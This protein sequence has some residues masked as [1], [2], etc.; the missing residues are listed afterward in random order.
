MRPGSGA[1]V[2]V[3]TGRAEPLLVRAAVLPAEPTSAGAARRLLLD[4]LRETGRERWADSGTL[5]ITEVVTNAVLH[6]ATAVEVT[7]AVLPDEVD[8]SVFDRSPVLPLPRTY[9][10]QATTGRGLRLVAAVTAEC[11][12]EPRDDPRGKDVWFRIR[13][14]EPVDEASVDDLLAAWDLEVGA[15][16]AP[17]DLDDAAPLATVQ[18]PELRTVTLRNMPAVLWLAARQHHDGLL[19][20]LA[21]YVAEHGDVQVDLQ[22]ADRARWVIGR[23]LLARLEQ[24]GID[25][26]VRPGDAAGVEPPVDGLDLEVAIPTDLVPA[27]GAL[28]DA[29]DAAERLAAAGR[30]LVR[31]GLP[32]IV[33]VRDWAC[34]QVVAQLAGA[35]ARPWG[36]VAQR[37]FETAF[38]DVTT[39]EP[40]W[41]DSV[42][43]GSLR[44]VVAADDANRIVAVSEP[45]AELVGLPVADLVGRRV[46]TLVP[47]RY[48][49][50]HVAGFSRYLSTGEAQVLGRPLVL[51]LLLADG[52]ETTCRYLVEAAPVRG[53][54]AVFLA[55]LDPL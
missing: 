13:D 45:L 4:A 30:L 33:A 32:E 6:A 54:R 52:R 25:L 44:C 47:A 18:E 23:A 17:D 20:E 29:L 24:A 21:L 14:E 15:E 48:R 36:G 46:V 42:V 28:Q 3:R 16:F 38:P 35:P 39:P 55:W 19:R 53:G 27:Y 41:D 10:P 51:P 43:T 2:R 11:G 9:G 8:V 31:P 7:V 5:A 49:E 37:E 12:V 26:G 1:G 34:E 50:A 22:L 40:R